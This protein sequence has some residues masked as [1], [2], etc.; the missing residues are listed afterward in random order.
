VIQTGSIVS[1]IRG[2]VGNE[3]FARNQGGLYVR[4]RAGPA[5]EP[6]ANQIAIHE[7]VTALSQVWSGTLTEAQRETW[8]TYAAQFP[9]RNQWGETSLKNGYTRFIAVNFPHHVAAD[10]IGFA[11]APTAPPLGPTN[12][13]FTA[14]TTPDTFTIPIP[15]LPAANPDND[16]WIFTYVGAEQNQGVSFY[17]HPFQ[18]LDVTTKTKTAWTAVALTI[19]VDPPAYTTAKKIWLRLRVQDSATG[20]LSTTAYASAIFDA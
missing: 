13:S 8:R 4:A 17:R 7:S 14:T 3:T 2:S 1:D 20:S 6:S 15:L 12:F 18:L 16:L 19:V 11:S 9:R 10:G 5:G